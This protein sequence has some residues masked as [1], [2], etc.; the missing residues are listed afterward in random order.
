MSDVCFATDIVASELEINQEI[1]L[2]TNHDLSLLS[3]NCAL[4]Q[5]DWA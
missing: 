2:D 1:L 4:Q 5:I 3:Y